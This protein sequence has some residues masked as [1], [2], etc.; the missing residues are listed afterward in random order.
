MTSLPDNA[1]ERDVHVVTQ[2]IA[3]DIDE[4]RYIKSLKS[5]SDGIVKNRKRR[6]RSPKS[7]FCSF[8]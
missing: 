7:N 2:T 3:S 1:E 8:V 5:A 6:G 4:T